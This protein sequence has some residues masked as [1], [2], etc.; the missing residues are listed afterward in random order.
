MD[1]VVKA[2]DSVQSPLHWA[3]LGGFLLIAII[4][5]LASFQG[6]Y[7]LDPRSYAV[8]ANDLAPARFTFPS[9]RAIQ[10][11]GRVCGLY[12]PTAAVIRMF[13]ISEAALVAYPFLVSIFGCLLAYAFARYLGTP[14][15][16]LVALGA[17]A[18]LPLDVV[19]SSLLYPDL[20]AAFWANVGIGL[21]WIA[22]ARP[23]VRQSVLLGILSGFFFG[24]SWLCK[25]TVAYPSRS[26]RFSPSVRQTL[27]I[28][29]KDDVSGGYR[30]RLARGVP[31][32]DGVLWQIYGRP[33]VPLPRDGTSLR[34][35][36]P[37][38]R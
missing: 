14:L 30:R 3:T 27:S 5:R 28:V 22:L 10:P 2:L 18:L 24:V 9:T 36:W 20:I 15:A 16:G 12:A 29:C 25:E 33:L 23:K 19:F 13:G 17:L 1:R 32:G 26:W 34:P 35:D 11:F 4:V 37:C 7:D 31:G 6:Y 38:V 21:A 8:L